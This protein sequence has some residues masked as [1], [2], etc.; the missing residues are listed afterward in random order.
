MTPPREAGD[1]TGD[2]A[3]PAAHPGE[4]QETWETWELR[5]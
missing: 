4:T 2:E 1:N 3:Q 5:L